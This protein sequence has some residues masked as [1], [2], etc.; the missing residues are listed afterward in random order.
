MNWT[1]LFA[2]TDHEWERSTPT[3]INN[4]N[5]STKVAKMVFNMENGWIIKEDYQC[6]I[7]YYGSILQ[8]V[9]EDATRLDYKAAEQ[10]TITPEASS[11]AH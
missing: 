2:T 6:W 10:D 1:N 11:I 5:K 8:S 9:Q 4:A 7:Y 3:R